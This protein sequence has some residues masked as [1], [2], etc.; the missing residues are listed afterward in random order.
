[1]SGLKLHIFNRARLFS[2]KVTKKKLLRTGWSYGHVKPLSSFHNTADLKRVCSPN[3]VQIFVTVDV[4]PL[5]WSRFWSILNLL[6]LNRRIGFFTLLSGKGRNMF[7]S[8]LGK[9]WIIHI[10]PFILYFQE[11]YLQAYALV[12]LGILQI[13]T[14]CVLGTIIEISVRFFGFWKSQNM[15]YFQNHF[16]IRATGSTKQSRFSIGTSCHPLRFETMEYCYI[17]HSS[18]QS[19]IFWVWENSTW[20]HVWRWGNNVMKFLT[21]EFLF[22]VFV[23]FRPWRRFTRMQ[24]C[25]IQLF[26]AAI[27]RELYIY[28][29]WSHHQ[30]QFQY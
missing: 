1:M 15:T 10:S 22:S 14:Y 11:N 29:G 30:A 23:I 20:K 16:F 7:N 9:L 27:G 8:E 17:I 12:L 18:Q 5:Y 25:C 19:F 3:L 28:V 24:W 26:K 6:S 2:F 21:K 13:V 4:S